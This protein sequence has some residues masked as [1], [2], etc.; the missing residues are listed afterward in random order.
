MGIKDW[1][2]LQK[3]QDT[4]VQFG[5][6]SDLYKTEEK[7]HS[8]DKALEAA[9]SS[10]Y[11]ELIHHFLDYLTN[12][13]GQ[14][15][16][17]TY[18]ENGHINFKIIQGSKI[19]MGLAMDDKVEVYIKIV[20]AKEPHLAVFRTL[21]EEN[22]ILKYSKYSLDEV[23]CIRISF[24]SKYEDINPYKLYYGLKE[25]ALVADHKDD[26]LISQYE[27]FDPIDV[28]HLQQVPN[29]IILAKYEY[30]QVEVN[31]LLQ[32]I[33][34]QQLTIKDH[35]TVLAYECGAFAYKM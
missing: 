6:Y 28:H 1:F 20:H 8:W 12:N 5:R 11:N 7:Y 35:V 10:N 2:F 17:V 33:E 22:F 9:Q 19:L 27:A 18:L 14:N 3:P 29:E 13:D 21:L 25:M 15:V 23:G 26:A 24:Q 34:Q 16:I 30:F 4:I 32:R 31:Q